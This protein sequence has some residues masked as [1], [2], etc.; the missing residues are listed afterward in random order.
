MALTEP[1]AVV[2]A[3]LRRHGRTFAEESGIRIEA[4][5]DAAFQVLLLALLL[6]ARIRAEVAVRATGALL[7]AG[8]GDPGALVAST[9]QQR[10][11]VLD[12]AGYARYDERTARQL[13]ICAQLVLDEYA[14]DLG[15]LRERAGRQTAAEHRL[16]QQFPGIGPLGA[17]IFV[18]EVQA[19]WIEWYP[20]ADQRAVSSARL[21]GLPGDAA[22]LAGLVPD[23]ATFVILVAA[24]VRCGLAKDHDSVLAEA[25]G[26]EPAA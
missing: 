15:G 13:G 1:A 26:P 23:R 16:L 22:G 4:G 12:R 14:G 9:W 19:E 17:T 10:V 11:D 5:G 3:L 21:L 6:S 8:W 25:S 18:R 20:F 24:L 7:D 2:R